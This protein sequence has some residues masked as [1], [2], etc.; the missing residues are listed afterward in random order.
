M[1][2]A[3]L[4]EIDRELTTTV[5]VP[6]LIGVAAI[7]ELMGVSTRQVYR[8]VHKGTFPKPVTHIGRYTRWRSSDY[9]AWLTAQET[10][11]SGGK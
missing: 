10:K 4:V 7:A 9:T 5:T 2:P 6:Q 11:A 3:P 8:M 1:K